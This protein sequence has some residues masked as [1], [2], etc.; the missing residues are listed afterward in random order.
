[1]ELID[2]SAPEL[3]GLAID[4]VAAQTGE[5][6]SKKYSCTPYPGFWLNSDGRV[7]VWGDSDALVGICYGSDGTFTFYQ[8]PNR[9][10]VGDAFKTQLFLVNT[11]TNKMIT[12]NITLN[13]V[14]SL[15]QKEE[16]GSENLVIPVSTD[17]KDIIL[18]GKTAADALGVTVADLL[19]RNNYYL[20]AMTSSGVYG[21]GQNAEMGLSFDL[22]GGYNAYGNMYFTLAG[23]EG[24]NI[25]LTMCSND[26]VD[27]DYSVDGQFCFEVGDKQYVYYVKFVSEAIYEGINEMTTQSGNNGLIY[28][29]TGRTVV[30]PMR[31]IYIQNGKKFVV[32]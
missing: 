18:N 9:N 16:V 8:Y 13:F 1:M 21:E 12:F 14:E 28:D 24:D 26:P 29:L 4:S 30:K 15:V 20:R 6:Y 2:T 10:S 22:D 32:K 11:E 25:V 23:G 19:D 17:E 7:S 5:I 27:S 3:Y 31:G